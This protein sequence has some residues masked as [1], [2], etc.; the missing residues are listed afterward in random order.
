MTISQHYN[1]F[2]HGV[3]LKDAF[4]Q[5]RQ[6]SF[7]EWKDTD[8]GGNLIFYKN[9]DYYDLD[10]LKQLFKLMNLNYP[11]EEDSKVSTNE[12]TSKE[13]HDHIE[14]AIKIL[15]EN[16]IEL[17]FISDEWDRLLKENGIDKEK[18]ND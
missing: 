17:Q 15:G 5:A 10:D 1:K 11:I 13:L 12:I 9:E 18:K 7:R 8:T 3:V 2:Y 16:G 6:I 14:W 4:N